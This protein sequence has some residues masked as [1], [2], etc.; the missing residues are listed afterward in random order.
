VP[1]LGRAAAVH[2][3]AWLAALVGCYVGHGSVN[4]LITT[5]VVAKQWPKILNLGYQTNK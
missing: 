3:F 1:H 4:M 5:H 2:R